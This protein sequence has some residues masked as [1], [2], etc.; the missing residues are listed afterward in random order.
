MLYPKIEECV[1][2][3]NGSKYMLTVMVAKRAKEL[4][5]KRPAEFATSA[6]K[7]LSYALNEVA[8]GRLV[9]Y[10]RT[11]TGSGNTPA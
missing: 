1:E 2:L 10:V 4:A 5:T 3:A 7:E 8:Q 11:G 9:P 6:K